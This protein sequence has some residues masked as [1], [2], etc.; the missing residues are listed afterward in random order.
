MAVVSRFFSLSAILAVALVALAAPLAAS[1]A[2]AETNECINLTSCTSV[3]NTPWVEVPGARTGF[4]E[5]NQGILDPGSSIW[6]ISCPGTQIPAGRDF[7]APEADESLIVG[8]L[9]P[10]FN[11][12]LTASPKANFYATWQGLAP[13]TYQPLVGCIPAPASSSAAAG[14]TRRLRL[15]SST[16]PLAPGQQKTFVQRCAKGEDLVGAEHGVAFYSAEP[17]SR[18]ELAKVRVK[19]SQRR[20]RVV[21]RASTGAFETER[22]RLQVHAFCRR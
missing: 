18:A 12:G 5:N 21:V 3:P 9:V 15:R 6:R 2:E 20:D 17:P 22:V 19:R 7:K 11:I 10:P 8:A 1:A 16:R 14:S 4:T 13:T